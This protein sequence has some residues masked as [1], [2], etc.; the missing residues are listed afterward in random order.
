MNRTGAILLALATAVFWGLYGPSISNA[1]SLK[2]PPEW[3][4]FKPFVFIGL[5]YLVWGCLVGSL[6]MKQFG[7]SFSFSGSHAPAAK[8][9]FIGGSMGAF[10]ALT[11]TFALFVSKGNFGLVMPIVFGGAVTMTA[12]VNVIQGK[13]SHNPLLWVG[14]VLVLCGIVLV[15]MHS[16]A[17]HAAPPPAPGSTSSQP[18]ASGEHQA[19]DQ[20]A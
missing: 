11:L 14:M 17:A 18:S 1:R 8:W 3:S 4:S 9:G 2:K 20:I 10:G 16:H 6:A 5:A 12:I 15:A 7:D 19:R 13:A